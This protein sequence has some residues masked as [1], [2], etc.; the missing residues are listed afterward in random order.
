MRNN[1]LALAFTTALSFS[2][3]ALPMDYIA[4]EAAPVVG[5]SAAVRGQVFVSTNGAERKAEIKQ[6]I[7]LQ[8]SVTTKQDSAL[9]ILLLDQS[10]FTV[11]Q[12]CNMVIDRF[13]YDPSN[14]GGEIGA[15][16]TKGAFR[17]MSGNIGKTNPT[18]ASISTPSATIGI[19]G[20]FFEGIVGGDAI[21]LAQLGGIN[22]AG[23][24]SNNASIIILRGPGPKSNTLDKIGALQIS[25][26]GGSSS[27]STPNYAVFDS[28]NGNPPTRPFKV[29]PEMQEYLDFF[30]RSQPDGPSEEPLPIG[31]DVENASGQDKFETPVIVTEDVF[32]ELI[33]GIQD[34]L[35]EEYCSGGYFGDNCNPSS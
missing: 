9:Q 6:S 8:D 10:T 5:T 18:S 26:A 22:T 1:M 20:T 23:A 13:V 28:G 33:D 3:L 30:L 21:A 4:A 2:P 11:G 15:T 12:N 14:N 31:E 27:I 16:I 19:R 29:T 34:S 32:E 7:Q 17:F 24:N 35:T 25:T